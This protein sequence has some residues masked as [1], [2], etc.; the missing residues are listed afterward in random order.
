[1]T[2]NEFNDAIKIVSSVTNLLEKDIRDNYNH[3][4]KYKNATKMVKA[5]L[6]A[7]GVTD[8]TLEKNKVYVIVDRDYCSFV[9]DKYEYAEGSAES[10]DI[11]RVIVEEGRYDF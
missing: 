2:P 7:K 5:V 11:C 3:P 8:F 10:T 4:S 1:M 6:I 9:F